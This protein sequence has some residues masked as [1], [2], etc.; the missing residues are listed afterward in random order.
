MGALFSP[1]RPEILF[2]YAPTFH[3][4]VTNSCSL[5]ASA[6]FI[7]RIQEFIGR[8]FPRSVILCPANPPLRSP[9]PSG[10]M[11]PLQ[12]LSH[13]QRECMTQCQPQGGLRRGTCL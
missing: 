10:T 3:A 4:R 11:V 12:N 5:S 1:L 6:S 7:R 13:Q 9:S 2:D 8:Y